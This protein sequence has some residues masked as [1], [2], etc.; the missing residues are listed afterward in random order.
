M[1]KKAY[2]PTDYKYA[3][4]LADIIIHTV[5]NVL[6][7]G[8]GNQ[9][10]FNIPTKFSYSSKEQ[11]T[12][13]FPARYL[14]DETRSIA[15]ELSSGM[16][17]GKSGTRRSALAAK[18]V[19]AGNCGEHADLAYVLCREYF[20]SEWTVCNVSSKRI[21]HAFVLL[22]RGDNPEMIHHSRDKLDYISRGIIVIDPWPIK[23][24][25]VLWHD[26]F[27]YDRGPIESVV[28]YYSRKRCLGHCIYSDVDANAKALR[29]LRMGREV[30]SPP[31][32]LQSG[33]LRR[34]KY[35]KMQGGIA[36]KKERIEIEIYNKIKSEHLSGTSL[37]G[38]Y[39]HQYVTKNDS[40]FIYESDR[41]SMV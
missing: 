22:W 32:V 35:L 20:S 37:R 27:L 17:K 2:I 6:R 3:I 33:I 16:R 1:N 18:M 19:G 13:N 10:H 31:I 11:I 29:S 5:K 25:S 23:A 41:L 24:Q 7:Y 12:T 4:D 15:K 9:V 26:H 34:D 38:Q 36:K 30:I 39:D 28:N 8:A 21:D 40:V 14:V